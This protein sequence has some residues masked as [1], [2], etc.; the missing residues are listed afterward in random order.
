VRSWDKGYSAN[1]DYTAGVLMSKTAEG[2]FTIEDVQRVRLNPAE[3]NRLIK[4]TACADDALRPGRRVLQLV[5]QPPG[6]GADTT[7]QLVRELAGHAV[8]AIRPVGKKEERAEPYS[9]QVLSGNVRLVRAK[10]NADF[11]SE[12]VLFPGG[13]ND[14]QVDAASTAFLA[15]TNRLP[16]QLRVL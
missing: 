12:H 2:L 11:V 7:Q 3:R 10:W 13:A 15:L 6:A 8:Q 9:A 5:E 4:A 1:G 14:D 16:L